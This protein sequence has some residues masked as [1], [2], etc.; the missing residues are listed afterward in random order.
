ML[1]D[2]QLELVAVEV[3]QVVVQPDQTVVVSWLAP[4]SAQN[5]DLELVPLLWLLAE[6]EVLLAEF[7]VLL[8][9]VCFGVQFAHRM[10]GNV[11]P[12]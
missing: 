3:L 11:P 12:K 9:T 8:S 2:V 1:E 6:F 10:A 5:S 7:E 4:A